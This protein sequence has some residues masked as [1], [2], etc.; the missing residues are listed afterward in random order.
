MLSVAL[1]TYNGEKF[2]GEQLKS[3][4]VQTL[5]PDELIIADDGS[6][7]KTMDIVTKF[8]GKAPFTVNVIQNRKTLGVQQNFAVASRVT[9]GDYIAFC[10]QDDV[11]LPDKL[12]KSMAVIKQ[13]ENLWPQQ[14]LL[15]H[16]DLC[17]TDED[18]KPKYQSFMTTQ[19]LS[20]EA[21]LDVLL[22]QNFVTGCTM[23]INR[24]LLDAALPFPKEIVMHDW[25]IALVA[26]ACG[27]IGFLNEATVYYRQHG[28]N[29][30]GAKKYFSL[31]SLMKFFAR[32]QNYITILNV[33]RQ[34]I[35]LQERLVSSPALT[36]VDKYL[37][38]IKCGDML[39]VWRLGI[40]KQGFWRNLLFY[41]YL[42]IYRQ[43]LVLDMA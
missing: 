11:W 13:L 35:N 25:W 40:H 41:L 10:D 3:L 7:D 6:Y 28:Y 30:V 43:R 15:V 5:L 14:P 1:C 36:L 18:L 2:I 20:F 4:A 17:V 32:E 27:H 24:K 19:G 12:A 37:A 31:D 16:S 8:A 33:L 26:A 42:I 23:L 39:G 9:K 38:C 21:G 34:V 22:V 29:S